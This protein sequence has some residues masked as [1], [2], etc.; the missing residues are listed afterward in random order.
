MGKSI[1]DDVLDAALAVIGAAD[2][3]TVCTTEPASYAQATTLEAGG[4]MLAGPAAPTFQAIAD[5]VGGGREI[6]VD[7]EA[8]IVIGAAGNAQHVAICNSVGSHLLA[9]TTCTL[10]ALILADTV[11]IPAWK[12]HI[13]DP[14]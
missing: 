9:V 4:R 10:H 2:I 5:A 12:I 3:I 13:D 14:V 1:H 6:E 8:A 7:Q 11:T